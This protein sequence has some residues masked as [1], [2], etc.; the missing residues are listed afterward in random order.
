MN[1]HASRFQTS[2]LSVRAAE[3]IGGANARTRAF[4]ADTAMAFYE[5]HVWLLLELPRELLQLVEDLHGPDLEFVPM[6][7]WWVAVANQLAKDG[8]IA[9]T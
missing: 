8:H 4:R 2:S 1:Q 9:T 5:R 6:I 3:R 7:E